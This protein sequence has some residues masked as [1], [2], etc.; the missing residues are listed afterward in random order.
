MDDAVCKLESYMTPSF[1]YNSNPHVGKR[2]DS[3]CD[4]CSLADSLTPQ[5]NSDCF[6]SVLRTKQARTVDE[7]MKDE[8]P[9]Y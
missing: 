1:I 4:A 3:R 8:L 7:F 5:I 6:Y 9:I 2:E